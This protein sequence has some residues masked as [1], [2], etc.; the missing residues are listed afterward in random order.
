MGTELP[1]SCQVFTLTGALGVI[2][3]SSPMVILVLFLVGYGYNKLQRFY[4][5]SSR[6]LR[7]LEST[8]ASPVGTILMDCLANAPV[9]RAQQLQN[10]FDIEFSK[11]LDKVRYCLLFALPFCALIK[12]NKMIPYFPGPAGFSLGSHCFSVAWSSTSI[13]RPCCHC[14]YSSAGSG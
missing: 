3:Y 8:Y 7:R 12:L 6:D 2:V 14:F 1:L 4:R 13:V 9:I 5:H 10:V 11:A